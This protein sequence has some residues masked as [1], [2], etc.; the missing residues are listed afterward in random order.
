MK[1]AY[2]L[3]PEG[4]YVLITESPKQF[5]GVLF[6]GFVVDSNGER[7]E[8]VFTT[9]QLKGFQPVANVPTAYRAALTGQPAIDEV[10]ANVLA[11]EVG[12]ATAL[13][14]SIELPRLQTRM[15]RES[16]EWNAGLILGLVL[17][18]LWFVFTQ[19]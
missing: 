11:L 1:P 4:D 3:R 6:A 2:Y 17:F 9:E 19:L 8:Q 12:I 16:W 7:Q 5:P 13:A 14:A 15:I 10:A 18:G